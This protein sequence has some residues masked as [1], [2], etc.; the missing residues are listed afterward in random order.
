MQN[1]KLS[2]LTA[3]ELQSLVGQI[4]KV[5]KIE[6][7]GNTRY[8]LI[9]AENFKLWRNKYKG[10][11]NFKI[12]SIVQ[13][14]KCNNEVVYQFHFDQGYVFPENNLTLEENGILAKTN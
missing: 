6:I 1:K 4:I 7:Y 10:T 2:E 9:A 11:V 5:Q 12:V 13:S 14:E 3:P 8:H